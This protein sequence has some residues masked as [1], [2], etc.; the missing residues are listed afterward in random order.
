ML[1]VDLD[2]Q[3]NAGECL[4]PDPPEGALTNDDLFA[5][6][7]AGCAHPKLAAT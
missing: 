7:R 5:A 3:N 4:C 2:P 1:V 6:D